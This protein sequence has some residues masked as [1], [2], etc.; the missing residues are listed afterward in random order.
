[1]R[2][3][4]SLVFFS[5]LLFFICL[6]QKSAAQYLVNAV[7]VSYAGGGVSSIFGPQAMYLNPANMMINHYGNGN[8]IEF[9]SFALSNPYLKRP[10]TID[11]LKNSIVYPFFLQEKNATNSV[12]TVPY[13]DLPVIS[14]LNKNGSLSLVSGQF[15]FKNWALGFGVR[16][17]FAQSSQ[18][19]K[20]WYATDFNQLALNPNRDFTQKNLHWNEISVSFSRSIEYLEGINTNLNKIYFGITASFLRPIAYQSVQIQEDFYAE[21]DGTYSSVRNTN[22]SSVGNYTALYSQLEQGL[23]QPNWDEFGISQQDLTQNKGWGTGLALGFTYEIPFESNYE[24]VQ[25]NQPLK[26]VFRLSA[27][28]TDLG[29][30]EMNHQNKN[31]ILSNDSINYANASDLTGFKQKYT[32]SVTEFYSLLSQS[33]FSQVLKKAVLTEDEK[34][35]QLLPAQA[36]AGFSLQYD[37]FTFGADAHFGLNEELGNKQSPFLTSYTQIAILPF[38]PIRAGA[39]VRGTQIETISVG[40]GLHIWNIAWDIGVSVPYSSISDLTKLNAFATTGLRLRF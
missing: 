16:S 7:Q 33:N 27:S 38:L 40:A 26:R 18:I 19:S 3:N 39:L 17:R 2:K 4:T 11:E 28:L 31:F 37:W 32:G 23:A 9:G 35:T 12:N 30:I 8:I 21:Q 34:I 14:D 5:T 36:H 1:M 10:E 24:R 13:K 29:F 22:L 6:Q 15:H 20:S 25:K